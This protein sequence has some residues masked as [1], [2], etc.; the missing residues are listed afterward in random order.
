[1]AKKFADE[2]STLEDYIDIEVV[3]VSMDRRLTDQ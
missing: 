3:T 2:L 1:M